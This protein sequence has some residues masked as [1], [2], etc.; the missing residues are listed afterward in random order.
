[1]KHKFIVFMDSLIS[2]DYILFGSI[3]LIFFI[4]VVLALVLRKKIGLSIFLILLA[5]VFLL[6]A[7]IAG[8][9]KMHNTIFKKELTLVSQKKLQFTQAAVVFGT[10]KNVSKKDFQSC[11]ITAIVT[12]K[13][14]NKYKNYIYGF[15][16]IK[17]MSIIEEDI[18]MGNE[19]EFKII[20]DP[21]TY[22]KDFN[23]K[24]EADCR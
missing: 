13:S 21:F 18:I 20:V 4:L 11:L 8:Y 1:M 23:I 5:F 15:K 24:L 10:L 9:T 22:Q 19:I 6:V 17:K 14:T 16:P 2:Y 12:K 3:F 7:P